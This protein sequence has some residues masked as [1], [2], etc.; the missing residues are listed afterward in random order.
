MDFVADQK[1]MHV[2]CMFL[3]L[4]QNSFEQNARRCVLISEVANPVPGQR[5]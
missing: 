2:V 4:S 3:L 5:H 1:V